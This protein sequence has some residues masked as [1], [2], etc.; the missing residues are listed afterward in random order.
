MRDNVE[1][2][3]P[4]FHVVIRKDHLIDGDLDVVVGVYKTEVSLN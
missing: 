4:F 1:L 2:L 3:Q